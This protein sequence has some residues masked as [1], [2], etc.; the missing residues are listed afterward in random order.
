M[1]VL[2]LTNDDAKY[3]ALLDI[4]RFGDD[5]GFRSHL[6]VRSGDFAGSVHFCFEPA[7]LKQFVA[8]IERMNRTLSGRAQLKPLYEDI[9]I[10]LEV[11]HTGRVTVS[12]ELVRYAEHTHR[13]QFGFDTDQTCL[14]PLARDLHACLLAPAV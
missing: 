10:T 5:A 11:H 8:E 7:P 1:D 4:Q 3:L 12:G 2:L 9:Q 6:A 14:A 13:L